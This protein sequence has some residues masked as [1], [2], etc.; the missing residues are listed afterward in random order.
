MKKI[1]VFTFLLLPFGLAAQTVDQ[2]LDVAKRKIAS[3]NFIEAKADLTKILET[4]PKNKNVFT[5]YTDKYRSNNT[6]YIKDNVAKAQ[7]FSS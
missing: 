1:I 3:K 7:R 5:P 6:L 2:L 4:N